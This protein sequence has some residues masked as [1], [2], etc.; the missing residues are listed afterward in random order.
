M[1][2]CK[3]TCLRF[4]WPHL[5]QPLVIEL[6]LADGQAAE[7]DLVADGGFTRLQGKKRSC[8][9]KGRFYIPEAHS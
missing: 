4:P 8:V 9:R 3:H 7:R 2:Q 6:I 5:L 1:Y